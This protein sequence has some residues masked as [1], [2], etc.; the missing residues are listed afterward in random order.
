M[1]VGSLLTA[2][3]QMMADAES[4]IGVF[5]KIFVASRT[6]ARE[7]NLYLRESIARMVELEANAM[8]A[9]A[10]A[11]LIGGMIQGAACIA[12]GGLQMRGA[13][14]ALKSIRD[15]MKSIRPQMKQ[16]SAALKAVNDAQK[17]LKG[18][19]TEVQKVEAQAAYDKALASHEKAKTELSQAWTSLKESAG[20]QE[21]IKSI[22]AKIANVNGMSSIVKGSGDM[23]ESLFKYFATGHDKDRS[24]LDALKLYLQASQQSNQDF[25]RD[26]AEINRQLLDQL[27]TVTDRSY[28]L[29]MSLG[30][31]V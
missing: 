26:L 29:G 11:Q 20:Y 19:K 4:L 9:A 7:R 15:G 13:I 24:L 28:Q 18:A 14:S 25:E 16:E 1:P 31:A 3:Q 2:R 30:Q 23:Q 27:R 10:S 21:L 5:L 6:A 12:S 8:M 17:G 22:D